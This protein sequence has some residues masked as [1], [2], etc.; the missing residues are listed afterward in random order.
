VR[1]PK[2]CGENIADHFSISYISF[3]KAISGIIFI[4]FQVFEIAGISELVQI[5]Y[6]P[7]RMFFQNMANEIAADEAGAASDK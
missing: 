3:N 5:G 4:I 6:L 7:I 1:H 2:Y